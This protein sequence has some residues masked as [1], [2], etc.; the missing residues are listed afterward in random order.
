MEILTGAME[1]RGFPISALSYP[2]FEHLY[3]TYLAPSAPLGNRT[4]TQTPNRKEIT[5]RES[6]ETVS[7][8]GYKYGKSVEYRVDLTVYW[9]RKTK[10]NPKG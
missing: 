9:R 4:N 2:P 10:E 5:D 6:G 8:P 3:P 7:V 1:I